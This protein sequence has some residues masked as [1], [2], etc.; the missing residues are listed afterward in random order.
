M[1]DVILLI[2]ILAGFPFGLLLINGANDFLLKSRRKMNERYGLKA[3]KMKENEKEA[4]L[5]KTAQAEKI[6]IEKK[7][8]GQD[9]TVQSSAVDDID[10]EYWG[11]SVWYP[12]LPAKRRALVHSY[13]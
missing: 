2:F 11:H 13:K 12:T 1:K 5:T 6:Q 7:E 3:F 9:K 8:Q 4:E 10:N